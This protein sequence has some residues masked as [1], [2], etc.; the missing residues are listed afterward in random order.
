MLLF[1]YEYSAKLSGV[2]SDEFLTLLG[3]FS[4]ED[5]AESLYEVEPP[6]DED[7]SQ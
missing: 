6:E 2:E 3:A 5:D 1:D 4:Y 7:E